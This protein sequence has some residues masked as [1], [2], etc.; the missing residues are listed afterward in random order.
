MTNQFALCS[1][2]LHLFRVLHAFP[3]ANTLMGRLEGTQA[4]LLVS[5]GRIPG[6]AMRKSPRLCGSSALTR[7][8]ENMLIDDINF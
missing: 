8:I 6:T 1:I 5:V 2:L 7:I 4:E 3:A